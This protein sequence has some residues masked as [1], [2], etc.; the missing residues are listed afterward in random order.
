MVAISQVWS[1]DEKREIIAEYE[2]AEHG[3][4]Q[5]VLLKFGISY[6][7]L[8]VWRAARDEGVLDA[9][10]S[11]RKPRTT[12]KRDNAEIARLRAEVDRLRGE[13]D[14]ARKDVE[15][16]QQAVEALGKAT[17]LLHELVTTRSA[18]AASTPAPS[19]TPESSSS[20]S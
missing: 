4:R 20:S 1:A 10:M 13:L 17:A 9:G 6:H 15:D 2:G 3:T 14:R 19:E 16:R 18:E 11:M 8:R 5:A 7:Q 12:P